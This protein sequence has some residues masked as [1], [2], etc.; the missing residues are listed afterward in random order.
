MV[1]GKEETINTLHRFALKVYCE[2]LFPLHTPHTFTV[3]S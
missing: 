1:L 2:S 3:N